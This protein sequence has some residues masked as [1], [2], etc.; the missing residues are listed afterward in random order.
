MS[1]HTRVV[2]MFMDVQQTNSKVNKRGSVGNFQL[3]SRAILKGAYGGLMNLCS[4]QPPAA[5]GV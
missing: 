3:P 5:P 4:R 1:S 2:V